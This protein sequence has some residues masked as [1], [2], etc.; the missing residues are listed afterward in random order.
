MLL[1]N[2][3]QHRPLRSSGFGF[4]F[5]QTV[6]NAGLEKGS[7][8]LKNPPVSDAFPQSAHQP[9]VRNRVKVALEVH[10]HHIHITLLHEAIHSPQG[11]FATPS[12]AKAV[13]VRG[14]FLLEDRL[15]D[16]ANCP[17]DDS[18]THRR[19]SQRP[20]LVAAWLQYERPPD[21]PGVD[22]SPRATPS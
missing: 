5:L 22:K 1:S 13:T 10:I 3:L 16:V 20:L 9:I 14:E 12:G 19:N 4:P 6:H 18:I 8:Q 11:V 7:D 17:L 2:G 21:Q 15:D